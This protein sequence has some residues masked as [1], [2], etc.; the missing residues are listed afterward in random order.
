[1]RP[2][3]EAYARWWFGEQHAARIA[4]VYAA[5]E[6]AWRGPILG[7]PEIPA[8]RAAV[9]TIDGELPPRYREGNWRWLLIRLRALADVLLQRKLRLAARAAQDLRAALRPDDPP[10]DGDDLARR[11]ATGRALLDAAG[12]E[13]EL[14]GLKRDL[15]DLD[16]AIHATPGARVHLPLIA[17]LDADV[18]NGDWARRRLAAAAAT[19]AAGDAAAAWAIARRVAGYEDAGPGGWY[20]DLGHPARAPHLRRG[21]P[22]ALTRQMDAANRPTQNTHARTYRGEPG[23][24]LA[25]D[26]LDPAA[27]YRVRLTCVAPP[28]RAGTRLV[29]RLEAGGL[30]VHDALEVPAAT[31]GE[32]V[33]SLPPAA[34][35]TGDLELEWI[36][37]PGSAGTAVSEVWLER[38]AGDG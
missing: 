19:L 5:L 21:H 32:Y 15:L 22:I 31:A 35:R 12:D 6:R 16:G 2:A 24:L 29:Q 3:L 13:A 30:P 38:V 18:G 14:A 26:G 9:E 8:L 23:V 33:F 37:A 20:D 11:L 17:R 7:N 10:A 34:Y 28:A 36:P 27:R 4:G 25:Y 1:V